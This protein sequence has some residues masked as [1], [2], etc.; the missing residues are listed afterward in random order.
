CILFAYCVCAAD[1][2]L[3]ELYGGGQSNTEDHHRAVPDCH[4]GKDFWQGH[5]AVSGASHVVR[6]G[7]RAH[8]FS[9]RLF[10]V[11][12]GD[13]VDYWLVPG[14]PVDVAHHGPGALSDS[15]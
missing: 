5:N 12:D 1:A 14:K 9:R 8:L 13:P 11:G 6:A 2:D 3:E 15:A 7:R 4:W 10:A